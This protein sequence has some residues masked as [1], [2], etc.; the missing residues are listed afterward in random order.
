VVIE[1]T[2][3]YRESPAQQLGP[4]RLTLE[5]GF[6]EEDWHSSAYFRRAYVRDVIT[7]SPTNL[8]ILVVLLASTTI[9]RIMLAAGWPLH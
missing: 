3:T 5:G 1:A 7:S 6:P 4:R 9:F 8:N 2:D